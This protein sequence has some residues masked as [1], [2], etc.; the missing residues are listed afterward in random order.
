MRLVC[1]VSL[2]VF[3]AQTL[4]IWNP[5]RC[6]TNGDSL[7]V[8][9]AEGRRKWAMRCFKDKIILVK[10][11][12][13][14]TDEKGEIRDAYP[15]FDFINDAGDFS[16]PLD[17]FAPTDPN[18]ACDKP[19]G[20]E[21]IHFCT[22]GCYTPEQTVLF[23]HGYVPIGIAHEQNIPFVL[24]LAANSTL[25]DPQFVTSSVAYYITDLIP[26]HH[27]ILEIVT[28]SGGFLSVTPNHP[29]VD[30]NGY[31]RSAGDLHIGDNLVTESGRFDR[32]ISI[33]PGKYF[34]KVYNLEVSNPEP[35]QKII[36]A[37]GYLNGTVYYQNEGLK[38]LNRVILRTNLI[39]DSLVR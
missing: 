1:L 34:G 32:I 9:Q 4:A 23:E 8:E 3:S 21:L 27:D 19:E 6:K 22:A 12:S 30:G 2:L 28:F 10:A 29:L 16:N 17:W 14:M 38:D 7:T 15:T 24:S 11:W 18:A 31:M 20:Y 39:P 35:S 5:V 33:R 36:V 37:Q 26:G 13:K 25:S